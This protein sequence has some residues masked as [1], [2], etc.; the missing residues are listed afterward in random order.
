VIL[1]CTWHS[2]G[3]GTCE[4]CGD[5]SPDRAAIEGSDIRRK[6]WV[7]SDCAEQV[8]RNDGDAHQWANRELSQ[9]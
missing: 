5:H 4:H 2:G 8:M 6:L 7:C 3:T 1:F 9:P